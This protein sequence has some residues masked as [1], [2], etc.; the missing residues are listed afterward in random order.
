VDKDDDG[1]GNED[2]DIDNDNGTVEKDGGRGFTLD[3]NL[4]VR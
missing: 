4:S 1:N 3:E 2:E